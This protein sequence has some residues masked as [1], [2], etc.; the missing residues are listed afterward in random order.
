M[1]YET[2]IDKARIGNDFSCNKK[3]TCIPKHK[4]AIVFNSISCQITYIFNVLV[5]SELKTDYF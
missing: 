1:F 3:I 5:I 4:L 2:D